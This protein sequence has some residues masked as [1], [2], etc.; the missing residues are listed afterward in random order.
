MASSQDYYDVLG[1]KK[2]ATA[3]EI[4]SAYRKLALKWHPDKHKDNKAEADKKFKAINEAY[5]VLSDPQKKQQYDQFGHAAFKQGGF[6][7]AARGGNPFGGAAGQGPFTYTYSHGCL[8]S[9]RWNHSSDWLRR[10]V[11]GCF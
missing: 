11:N 5:E 2:G 7:G 6:G 3:A 10:C 4:K 9:E 8:M 1:L